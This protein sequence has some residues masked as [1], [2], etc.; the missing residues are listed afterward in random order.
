MDKPLHTELRRIAQSL[1]DN[2]GRKV[3]DACPDPDIMLIR[4]AAD[5]LDILFYQ[6]LAAERMELAAGALKQAGEAA[7]QASE[8]LAEKSGA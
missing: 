7:L 3:Y 4:Q 6:K 8:E 1:R 5:E 2:Y